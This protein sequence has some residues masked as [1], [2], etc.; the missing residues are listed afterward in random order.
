MSHAD[1]PFAELRMIDLH[2]RVER[3]LLAM[4]RRI[5]MLADARDLIRKAGI[6]SNCEL[7]EVLQ[8]VQAAVGPYPVMD[9]TLNTYNAA[10]LELVTDYDSEWNPGEQ[11]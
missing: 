1:Q 4:R 9:T 3:Q 5:E 10:L 6:R 11:A 2:A 8:T 7:L